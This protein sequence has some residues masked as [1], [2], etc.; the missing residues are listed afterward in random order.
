MRPISNTIIVTV[1]AKSSNALVNRKQLIPCKQYNRTDLW[2]KR[3]PTGYIHKGQWNL[4]H[5]QGI[6]IVF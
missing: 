5:C 4:R 2:Y 6:S 1:D 3:E